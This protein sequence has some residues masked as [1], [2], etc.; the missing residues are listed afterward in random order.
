MD[1]MKTMDYEILRE[2]LK[3]SRRSDRELAKAL[4]T[5][6][7]TVTRRRANIEKNFV[8]GYTAIP[9]WEKIGFEIVAFTFIKH[10]IK[11]AKPKVREE[12][13]RKVK[14]WMMKHPNVILAI[15][16]QGMGWDAVFVSIHRNYG[17]FT[18]FINE[19][20][21]DLSESL[22]DCQSFISNINPTT[23]KKPFHLK[24]LSGMM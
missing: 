21:S 14:E 9:R 5:S 23:I 4:G 18:E 3:N 17:D 7:P 11:F 19:H 13:F 20:N 16:G 8:D 12:V 2:L 10:N 22:I 1:K 24:Y 6:Q 15:D